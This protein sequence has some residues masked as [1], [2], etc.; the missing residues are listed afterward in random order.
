VAIA[1]KTIAIKILLDINNISIEEVT[2][3]LH[4]VHQQRKPTPFLDNHGR[5][6]LCK[7]E[8][9]AK[10]KLRDFE[11]KGSGSNSSTTTG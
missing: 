9:M 3:M 5:L 1:I 10:L 2:G 11:G 6:L 8:W 7:E 4:V